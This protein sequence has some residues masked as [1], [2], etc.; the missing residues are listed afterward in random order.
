MALGVLERY[1]L[2]KRV[3]NITREYNALIVLED[4]E[5]LR[6]K[7]NG[8][9]L[10]WEMQMWCYRRVQS[11]IEYKALLEGIRIIYVDPRRSSKE[12]PNGKPLKFI[13]YRFVKLGEA[14][15]SRD[16][17]ASWNIA[18]RG[19]KQMR[20]SRVMWSPDSSAGE[21]MRIRSNAGG[22][23]RRETCIHN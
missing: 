2:A 11:F 15:T 3:V 17:V 19:L 12:P 22:T 7:A 5:K 20:G 9:K 8:D 6:E 14:V 18:S 10:S 21:E 23:P 16:V 1:R 4:L 13:N